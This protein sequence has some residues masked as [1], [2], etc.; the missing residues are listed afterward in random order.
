[1]TLTLPNQYDFLGRFFRL[2]LV[3]VLSNIMV[4]L[5]ST[6]SIIFLG[7]LD[8][9]HHLAGV[10]LTGTLLGCLYAFFLFLRMGTTGVTAQAVGRDDQ[11]EVLLVGLRNGLI[12]L[13]LG[14]ALVLL[15]YPLQVLGFS[16]L[17]AADEVKAS[18]IA[19]FNAQIWAAPAV[20]LNCVLL[21]WFL[22]REHNGKVLLLSFIGNAANIALDYLLIFRWDWASTGAGLSQA[23]SQ[24]LMLLVGL[25]FLCLE[26]EWQ[27][28]RAVVGK[29]W[30]TDAI[31]A[32]ITLN[33][34]LFIAHFVLFVTFLSFNYQSVALGTRIYTQNA[35][36]LQIVFLCS[37]GFEGLGFGVETLSGNFKGKG[38]NEKLKPL[39]GIA[40]STSLLVG[41][42]IAG[43]CMLFPM[44]VFGLLTNHTE[45]IK[46]INSYVP[47][48]FSVL[49]WE[50]IYCMLIGYFSGLAQGHI[51]RNASLIGTFFGFAPVAIAASWFH[52]N[53][54]LW[55]ALSLWSVT[56][57]VVFGVQLP[58]TFTTDV[59]DDSV[60]LP[61]IEASRNFPVS[62][63]ETRQQMV[64]EKLEVGPDERSL[65]N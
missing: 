54:I 65:I 50:S 52:S 61:A 25:V 63:E 36:L 44:S 14:V 17:D 8:E 31:T 58:K 9:I 26:I 15:Q 18:A 2:A 3:N 28:V 64:A 42:T 20:L 62:I 57:V 5:A 59:G 46:D 53:H 56:S 55:L 21:G 39:V 23:A 10:A 7:H 11:Q 35:L 49:G 48:L 60:S 4:P 29:I 27:Q 34:N 19:C 43:V 12:A 37:Y 41:L 45:V 22:G 33:G 13:V 32:T 40:T 16:L 24:Y 6:L 30:D 38:A 1:M 51:V 47:W